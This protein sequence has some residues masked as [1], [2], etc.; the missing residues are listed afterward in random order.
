MPHL[1]PSSVLEAVC[2]R[3]RYTGSKDF[4][5]AADWTPKQERDARRYLYVP[6]ASRMIAI[7][8]GTVFKTLEYGIAICDDGIYWVNDPES[9]SRRNSFAWNEYT[10]LQITRS[11]SFGFAMGRNIDFGEG[12]TFV[13]GATDFPASELVELLQIIQFLVCKYVPAAAKEA[14]EN[15]PRRK[16]KAGGWPL[17]GVT[18]WNLS[19]NGLSI[20]PFGSGWNLSVNE[21]VVGPF[22]VSTIHAIALADELDPETTLAWRE[23]M[24]EWQP[25]SSISRLLPTERPAPPPTPPLGTIRSRLPSAKPSVAVRAAPMPASTSTTPPVEVNSASAEQLLRL[26]FMTLARVK[27][28]VKGRQASNGLSSLDDLIRLCV[29]KPH[30]ADQIAPRV[31]FHAMTPGKSGT[32]LGKRIVDF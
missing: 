32:V 22:D 11:E 4:K 17:P 20:G 5:M 24:S 7:I 13:N 15:S 1:I 16:L 31:V 2:A 12:S 30:E 6:S 25:V 29:L 28:I 14:S 26:P 19:V 23:G 18:G 8:D 21:A 10:P 27:A 3:Y 9:R